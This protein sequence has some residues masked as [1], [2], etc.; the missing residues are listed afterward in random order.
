MTWKEFNELV[1]V[2][3]LV[4]SE[5][6]GRGVQEKIDTLIVSAVRDM[7]SYVPALRENQY[8]FYSSAN[9]VEPD[10]QDLSNVN[11]EDT[12]VHKGIF[13]SAR[14][15]LKQVI[16]RRIPTTENGQELSSY[17]TPQIIPW[18]SRFALIN[19][20]VSERTS[21][22]PGR[23]TFGDGKFWTGPKLRNDEAIYIYFDGELSYT[24]MYRAT[25]DEKNAPVILD[26]QEAKAASD[27]VKSELSKD[28]ENDLKMHMAYIQMYQK[29]RAL[30]FINRKDYQASSL[31]N[32]SG[33]GTGGFVVG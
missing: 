4:D 18:E 10:P 25:E 2:Y 20:G 19:G 1:R 26:E 11:S 17:F 9:L 29:E 21:G 6:K 32:V 15:R 27:F 22:M 13:P 5:R 8:K 3:L 33:V 28:V 31:E 12:D 16:V 14:S 24:P 23:I 7:S 30:I